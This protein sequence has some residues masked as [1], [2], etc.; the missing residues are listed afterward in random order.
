MTGYVIEKWD[1]E[2]SL[3]L[4]GKDKPEVEAKIVAIRRVEKGSPVA[5]FFV[6]E[7]GRVDLKVFGSEQKF[8]AGMK[9]ITGVKLDTLRT[10]PIY[11]VRR[12]DA[13]QINKLM[14]MPMMKRHRARIKSELM[15]GTGAFR[16]LMDR[17]EKEQRAKQTE[18]IK[19]TM[20]HNAGAFLQTEDDF[21]AGQEG[22]GMF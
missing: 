11:S 5:A 21:Y 13:G 2:L 6:F 22:L 16:A 3:F 10:F 15:G 18:E 8:S 12:A 7:S 1:K 19:A 9:M 14:A 20:G 4:N 17:A